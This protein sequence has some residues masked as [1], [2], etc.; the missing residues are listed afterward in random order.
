MILSNLH[1]FYAIERELE[2]DEDCKKFAGSYERL[3]ELDEAIDWVIQRN[4]TRF[5][6]IDGFYMWKTDKI[7]NL[8]SLLIIFKVDDAKRMVTLIGIEEAEDL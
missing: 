6:P 4:P 2:F 1:E 8:P 5:I 7:I 3:A